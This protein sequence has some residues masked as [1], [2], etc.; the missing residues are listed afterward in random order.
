[1]LE[2]LKRR[3]DSSYAVGGIIVLG[4]T[5]RLLHLWVLH[6]NWLT[7]DSFFY[8]QEAI[9]W[10]EKGELEFYW[11]PALIA[12]LVPFVGLLGE[13]TGA[14]VASLTIWGLFIWAWQLAGTRYLPAWK[15]NLGHLI[16]A[17]FPA[18]VHQSV[19]PLSQLP[20]ACCLLFL[21]YL[22]KRNTQF[23]W[24]MMG[25]LLG[26]MGLIRPASWALIPLWLGKGIY[27]KIPASNLILGLVGLMVLPLLWEGYAWKQ[28]GRWLRI[29]DANSYN[30]YLGNHPE[31]DHYRNWWLGSHE[32]RELKQF[33]SFT[34]ERDSIRALAIPEQESTYRQL[35]WGYIAQDPGTFM[36]RGIN[37]ARVFWA[38]DILTAGSMKANER[39]AWWLYLLIDAA[40]YVILLIGAILFMLRGQRGSRL[41]FLSLLLYM[42]PYLLAFAHPSYHFP[43]LPLMAIGMLKLESRAWPKNKAIFWIILALVLFIQLEWSIDLLARFR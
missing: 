1:M 13:S 20:I 3:L 40:M 35:A 15:V 16:W 38:Y 6:P 31:A 30:L 19:I 11:P 21:L 25:L 43:L 23:D 33:E 17:V 18:F 39:S 24:L 29:N 42:L 26:L 14:V 27:Q 10:L 5:L 4:L 12:W 37:R 32:S 9:S 7:G 2:A 28:T 34:S 22:S 8:V 36:L 41:L